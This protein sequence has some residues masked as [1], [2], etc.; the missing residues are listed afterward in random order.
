MHTGKK[1]GMPPA[2]K[3]LLSKFSSKREEDRLDGYTSFLKLGPKL[4][5]FIPGDKVRIIAI[6]DDLCACDVQVCG[7]CANL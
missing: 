5:K 3:S 7:V 1:Q 2:V 4:L 6:A